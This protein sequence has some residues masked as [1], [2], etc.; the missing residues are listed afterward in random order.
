M[1][2]TRLADVDAGRHQAD[3]PARLAVAGHPGG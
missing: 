1:S 2:L 3:R